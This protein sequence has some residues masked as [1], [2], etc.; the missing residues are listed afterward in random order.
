MGAEYI[1]PRTMEELREL[2]PTLPERTAVLA[3]GTDLM[4]SLIH[5]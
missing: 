1:Q 2:L 4:L 3:G 5:I